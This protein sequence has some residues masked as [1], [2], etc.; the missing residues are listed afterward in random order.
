MGPPF[1]YSGQLHPVP[2]EAGEPNPTSHSF[3]DTLDCEGNLLNSNFRA[4]K[5]YTLSWFLYGSEESFGR[6]AN[7]REH[8]SNEKYRSMVSQKLNHQMRQVE[9]KRVPF[10]YHTTALT[11]Q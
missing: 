6:E 7:Q 5:L 8:S 11:I 1:H 4:A 3:V 10:V 9:D 2:N